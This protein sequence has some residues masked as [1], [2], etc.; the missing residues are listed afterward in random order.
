MDFK[1]W[2]KSIQTASY[3]G[4]RMVGCIEDFVFLTSIEERRIRIADFGEIPIDI[5]RGDIFSFEWP[6]TQPL[7]SGVQQIQKKLEEKCF[8]KV[9]L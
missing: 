5:N 1:K 6:R 2:V 3:H 8:E 9:N 7:Y 4:A